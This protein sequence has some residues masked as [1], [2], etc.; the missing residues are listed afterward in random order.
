M[1]AEPGVCVVEQA[2]YL[3]PLHPSRSYC[4]ARSI[5]FPRS[6]RAALRRACLVARL[7]I[8]PRLKLAERADLSGEWSAP[9]HFVGCE[10][11]DERC[12][13]HEAGEHRAA[14]AHDELLAQLGFS[15]RLR[16]ARAPRAP[17][18]YGGCERRLRA[19][20]AVSAAVAA[21]AAA[22]AAAV[23]AASAAAASVVSRA[24]KLGIFF[25]TCFARAAGSFS[26]VKIRGADF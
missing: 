7:S 11:G 15:S 21:A 3:G 23:A 9:F 1:G 6:L 22:A 10:C 26:L 17:C 4:S 16:R 14:A 12:L 25:F 8:M 2:A 5:P 13:G 20:A 18:K 24:F 19:G